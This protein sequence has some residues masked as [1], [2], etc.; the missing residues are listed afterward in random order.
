MVITMQEKLNTDTPKG[1]RVGLV[2]V[3]LM[4]SG[5]GQR[6]LAAGYPLTVR[7]VHRQK[8]EPLLADGAS[9][10]ESPA[11]L[12]RE[13]EVILLSLPNTESVESVLFGEGG[14][15]EGARQGS[16]VVDMSTIAPLAAQDFAAQLAERGIGMLD[17]PVSGGS[18]GARSGK[19]S[20]MVGGQAAVLE[21][22]RPV[23]SVLASTI[24]HVG[25]HGAGQAVKM[26]NQV[27]LVGNVLAMSEGI[28]LAQRYGLNLEGTL[29]A[30]QEGAAGSWMLSNLAPKVIRRD[31]T[32]S[33]S[34]E[35]QLKDLRI[36]LETA[37]SLGV[38]LLGTSQVF[39]LY[40]SIA[41]RGGDQD[42]N[43]SLIQAL[44]ALAGFRI[45]E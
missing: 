22:V 1:L 11:N 40:R 16:V 29:K 23:L 20:T 34:I 17:A 3:G 14:V 7:D 38:P 35:L 25:E 45:D 4:G 41:A 27:V 33:F 44:E 9:W 31:W 42:G 28:L 39:Q 24:T 21:R 2:G 10:A 18:E 26:V 30:I 19:L 36:A 5:M 32:P 6:L 37:D 13:S 43:H 15:V 8:A 12:A